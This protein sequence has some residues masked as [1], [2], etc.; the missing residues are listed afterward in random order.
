MAIQEKP[1]NST[2]TEKA[3]NQERPKEPY[4]EPLLIKHGA[5][6]DI[7]LAASLKKDKNET[8]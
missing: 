2:D 7:T 1:E 3:P 6:R 5:L 8:Q 4:Q